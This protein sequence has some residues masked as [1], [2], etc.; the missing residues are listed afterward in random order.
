MPGSYFQ[1]DRSQSTRCWCALEFSLNK[2]LQLMCGRRAVAH[3]SLL[4]QFVVHIFDGGLPADELLPQLSHGPDTRAECIY[5]LSL[6][7]RKVQGRASGRERR[8][9]WLLC[10]FQVFKAT[11]ILDKIY[12][13][14]SVATDTQVPID[15]TRSPRSV[16]VDVAKQILVSAD[17]LTILHH[18]FPSEGQELPSWVP[19]WSKWH[20]GTEFVVRCRHL[21][22]SG[23]TKPSV[24]VGEVEDKIGL[25]G[26]LLGKITFLGT[27]MNDYYQRK[28]DAITRMQWAQKEVDAI[29]AHLNGTDPTLPMA[30]CLLGRDFF[31][32]HKLR[33]SISDG[34]KAHIKHPKDIVDNVERFLVNEFVTA[35]RRRSRY[36]RLGVLSG[37]YV[38]NVPEGA[39]EGDWIAM[40]DG[41]NHLYVLR[42]TGTEGEFAYV[43][44]SYVSGLMQGEILAPDS[45]WENC[46]L[47]LV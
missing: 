29:Q 14:M 45:P 38:A 2:R 15:Y 27:R 24:R 21:S 30:E 20:F 32:T 26:R 6:L 17:D 13:L 22:P 42:E 9:A 10:E 12:S 1:S 43:G 35:V 39:K 4:S 25:K 16:Y 40:L 28:S 11:Q 46:W 47:T 44:I 18:S 36:S 3:W 5:Q 7:R 33:A 41:G 19:D 23:A 37:E 8:L 31:L 34:F